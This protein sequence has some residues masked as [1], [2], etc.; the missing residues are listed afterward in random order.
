MP[1]AA[2]IDNIVRPLLRLALGLLHLLA[3]VLALVPAFSLSLRS[4]PRSSTSSSSAA[5]KSDKPPPKHVQ[6]LIVAPSSTG[7]SAVREAAVGQ[8]V[9]ES[10]ARAV[11]WATAEGVT[12]LSVFEPSGGCLCSQSECDNGV[13]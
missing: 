2:A 10:I 11:A 13:C 8:L 5:G 4:R 1:P 3:L 12:E 6:L 7:S 9:V